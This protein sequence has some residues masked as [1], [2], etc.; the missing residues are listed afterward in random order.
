MNKKQFEE[1]TKWQ[2]KTFT[3][4]TAT[5]LLEHLKQEVDELLE[6]VE[7][8]DGMHESEMSDCLILLFGVA[9]KLG[10]DYGAL[11]RSVDGKMVI[12]K[13][14][15]WQKPKENGVV[16]HVKEALDCI[17]CSVC[18]RSYPSSGRLMCGIRQATVAE[19]GLC[20]LFLKR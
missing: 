18:F 5:S 9:N 6:S 17:S 13:G 8:V 16:N 11:A 2:D 7:R 15:T 1:V 10:M 19:N 12:N 14:R 20:A 4:T 3:H